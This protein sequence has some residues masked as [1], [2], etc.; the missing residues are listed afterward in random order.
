VD[1]REVERPWSTHHRDDRLSADVQTLEVVDGLLGQKHA[2]AGEDQ[3]E[4]KWR[5]PRVENDR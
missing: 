5:P 3:A 1:R 2:V 4:T